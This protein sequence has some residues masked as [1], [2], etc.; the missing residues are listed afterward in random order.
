M[1]RP[2]A[3]LA[4]RRFGRLLVVEQNGKTP[5]GNACW[6]CICDCGVKCTYAGGDLKKGTLVSCGCYRHELLVRGSKPI[7]IEKRF[8]KYVKKTENCWLWTGAANKDGRGALGVWTEGTTKIAARVSWEIHKGPIPEGINVCHHC[9]NPACV[10][11]DHL[12]LGTQLDNIR[13]AVR[14]GRMRHVGSSGEKNGR[15]KLTLE[16]VKQIRCRAVNEMQ[17]DLAVEF[18]ISA[19]QIS[20]IVRG[21]SWKEK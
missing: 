7:P 5:S 14:K 17:K 10:R 8:W 3:N 6:L 13:D 18:G 16:Q 11:P 12:F 21:A 2:I 9:D 19:A 15:A 20:V 1:G 4:G